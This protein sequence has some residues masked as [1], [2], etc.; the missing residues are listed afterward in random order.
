MRQRIRSML[1]ALALALSLGAVPVLA[2]RPRSRNHLPQ[3]RRRQN[4]PKLRRGRLPQR[5]AQKKRRKR[6]RRI[7]PPDRIRRP[8][9]RNWRLYRTR[10]GP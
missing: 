9:E 10:W 5:K 7:L 4:R 3:T 6:L 8:L 1:L 2:D